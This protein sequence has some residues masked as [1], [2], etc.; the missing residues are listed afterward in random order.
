[1][2]WAGL[3]CSVV[4]TMLTGHLHLFLYWILLALLP[5][6]ISERQGASPC[7]AR[8]LPREEIHFFML[9]A[10]GSGK[11]ASPLSFLFSTLVCIYAK[12][13]FF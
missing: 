5:L 11:K 7:N 9:I 13:G 6:H 8:R 10:Q 3:S 12:A 4:H 1:M 2:E